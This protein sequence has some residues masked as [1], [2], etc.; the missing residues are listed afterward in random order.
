MSPQAQQRLL[1]RLEREHG[2]Q[3]RRA[4]ERSIR[5]L[6]RGV[7]MGDLA[8]M[9]AAGDIEGV[10][11]A[12]GIAGTAGTAVYRDLEAEI[13]RAFEGA[14]RAFTRLL[15][16][17]VRDPRGLQVV[18][19]FDLR[20]PQA[21]AWL[22]R[23]AAGLITRVV[24][25]QRAAVRGVL[26]DDLARGIPPRTSALRIA[27]RINAT[28]RVRE[29]GILGLSEP[30]TR[31]LRNARDYLDAGDARYFDLTLRD[32]RFDS[33]VRRAMQA[34]QSVPAEVRERALRQYGNRLMRH[35][36]ETIAQTETLN[37]LRA[38]HNAAF[39]Q[40]AELAGVDDDL[41][42]HEWQDTGDGKTRRTHADADGQ[43]IRGKDA[44]FTVGGYPMRWP[45]DSGLGAPARETIRCR[46][47]KISR[48]NFVEQQARREEQEA[49]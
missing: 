44:V 34:G 42:E 21:E 4:F 36:G 5:E 33:A 14:G 20:H 30:Q 49:A 7:N 41:I 22:R 18:F 31:Y 28:T 48:I 25:D 19:R 39:R 9:I 23:E 27:G 3:V 46:C 12:L 40:G 29:G 1:N 32:K 10:F 24:E 45:G 6:R 2:P 8:R 11:V 43:V 47:R 26:E 15:P 13:A 16:K 35:R 37:A 17:N 38:G